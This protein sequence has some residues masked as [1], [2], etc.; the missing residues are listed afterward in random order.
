VKLMPL[1]ANFEVSSKARLRVRA[2]KSAA[3]LANKRR[4][5]VNAS[6]KKITSTQK[7][8]V[9]RYTGP[10]QARHTGRDSDEAARRETGEQATLS[11]AS[12][13]ASV[14]TTT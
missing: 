9:H 7:S 3:V 12:E 13:A 11:A 2:G 6:G 10:A 5:Q 4:I 8:A 14:V 1:A